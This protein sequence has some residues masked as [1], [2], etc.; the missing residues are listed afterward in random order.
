MGG[1]LDGGAPSTPAPPPP[2]PPPA[3][4]ALP[5]SP[6]PASQDTVTARKR[7]RQRAS[8]AKGRGSTIL[9]SG[10]GLTEPG[11]VVG[12]TVLGA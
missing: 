10:L 7:N 9:T 12:K 11:N 1:L 8:L 6:R 2:P 5:P 3:V 4:P